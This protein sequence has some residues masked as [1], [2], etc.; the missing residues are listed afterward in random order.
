[1]PAGDELRG[2]FGKVRWGD[3]G[4]APMLSADEKPL[5][6]ARVG[7]D[8]VVLTDRRVVVAKGVGEESIPLEHVCKA[9]VMFERA[10]GGFL[11]GIILLVIAVLVGSLAG[12]TRDFLG[13]QA[14]ALDANVRQ[15]EAPPEPTVTEGSP[16][17]TGTA[18]AGPNRAAG[19]GIARGLQRILYALQVVE[20]VITFAAWALALWALARLALTAWGRTTASISSPAGDITLTRRGRDDALLDLVKELGRRAPREAR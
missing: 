17:P 6:Q 14:R 10:A 3:D 12:P 19:Q 7:D 16:A 20:K 4:L 2:F 18:K 5:A 11:S 8:M 15:L 9:R 1:M 13:E